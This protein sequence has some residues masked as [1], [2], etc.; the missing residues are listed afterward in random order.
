MK[1]DEKTAL[2]VLERFNL[3]RQNL[4]N[5]RHRNAIP[6]HYFEDKAPNFT[7]KYSE[8]DKLLVKELKD[9]LKNP[10]LNLQNIAEYIGEK[11]YRMFDFQTGKARFSP[12][13]LKSIR[14][15]LIKIRLYYRERLVK[16][17]ELIEKD[18]IMSDEA[19]WLI[20][21]MVNYPFQHYCTVSMEFL[22]PHHLFALRLRMETGCG[23]RGS[24]LDPER[25]IA[26][27]E[28]YELF[29]LEISL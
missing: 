29:I 17:R 19:A 10:K 27:T 20:V 1:Y 4:S 21:E 24:W 28:A 3:S 2:E 11:P 7:E 25:R 6:D 26:A 15:L 8:V 22:K 16:L 12:D 5:W 18:A 13:T 9:I 23:N 14:N